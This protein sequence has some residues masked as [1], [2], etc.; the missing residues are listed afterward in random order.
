MMEKISVLDS[1]LEKLHTDDVSS[2]STVVELLTKISEKL[3][4][5]GNNSSHSCCGG[6][7]I[8]QTTR[9]A[10][11][12]HQPILDSCS[13]CRDSKKEK[14]SEPLASLPSENST[15]ETSKEG[16]DQVFATSSNVT[17]MRT[18][19]VMENA[20]DK[21]VSHNQPSVVVVSDVQ[22]E[23]SPKPGVTSSLLS[24]AVELPVLNSKQDSSVTRVSCEAESKASGT[25][26]SKQAWPAV[27]EHS[28]KGDDCSVVVREGNSLSNGISS[29]ASIV[30]DQPPVSTTASTS[31]LLR[32]V[33][34]VLSQL[35]DASLQAEYNK[36][37][38][39]PPQKSTLSCTQSG[40]SHPALVR[41]M[42]VPSQH[43]S[44]IDHQKGLIG[45]KNVLHKTGQKEVAEMEPLHQRLPTVHPVSF[46]TVSGGAG[47]HFLPISTLSGT[48]HFLPKPAM[49]VAN[50]SG[51]Q[52]TNHLHCPNTPAVSQHSLS[53]GYV[54]LVTP[55]PNGVTS[56]MPSTSKVHVTPTWQPQTVMTPAASHSTQQVAKLHVSPAADAAMQRNGND[57]DDNNNNHNDT[58]TDIDT[59][60]KFVKEI[61]NFHC[62]MCTDS[63]IKNHLVIDFCQSNSTVTYVD[64]EYCPANLLL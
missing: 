52:S 7:V 26:C 33:T 53:Q 38:I 62:Y 46:S 49:L 4:Q 40:S 16:R 11:V 18:L 51:V 58:D 42:P 23:S 22:N 21:I 8:V 13:S 30:V 48:S 56:L 29:E 5:L 31:S 27:S 45:N 2:H 54:T 59:N 55:S 63:E 20:S 28:P 43:S 32:E 64:M 34:T 1:K 44:Y 57:D 3:D 50:N 37:L 12:V 15:C 6:P 14:R 41:P 19:T 47:R 9:H 35:R 39:L 36:T 24:S 61:H 10:N 25:V 60:N 17:L